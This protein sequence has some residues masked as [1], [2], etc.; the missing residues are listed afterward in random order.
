MAAM[1]IVL[2]NMINFV[3]PP[4]TVDTGGTSIG[5]PSAGTKP[6]VAHTKIVFEASRGDSAGAGIL[7]I[8]TMYG[9]GFLFIWM[10]KRETDSENN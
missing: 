4:L 2:S 3:K 1:E 6:P 9:M 10:C 5:D 8:L 7:T